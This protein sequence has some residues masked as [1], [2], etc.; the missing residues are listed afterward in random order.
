MRT[1]YISSQQKA[2]TFPA[3]FW[4]L[5]VIFLAS[6]SAILGALFALFAPIEPPIITKTLGKTGLNEVVVKPWKYTL[7]R[8]VNILVMGIDQVPDIP[9]DSPAIFT[10]RSDSLLLVRFHPENGDLNVLSIPRDTQVEIPEVGL[11]KINQANAIGGEELTQKV[12]SKT[13]NN[14]SIDRYVRVSTGAFRE[15]VDLLGGVDVFV[16]NSMSYIDKTQK[17]SIQLNPGWQTLNGEQ[18]EKFSRF[19][20]VYGD[21]GR[22]QRQQLLMQS[23]RTRLTH[24]TPLTKLPQMIRVMQKYVDTNLS[25]EEILAL[26]NFSLNLEPSQIKMLMLPGE[27]STSNEVEPTNYW[28]VDWQKSDRMLEEYFDQSSNYPSRKNSRLYP[29]DLKI[30]IQ[31]GS[32]NRQIAEKVFD[33]LTE[34][35]FKNVTIEPAFPLSQS[36]TTIIVQQGDLN[37]AKILQETLGLGNLEVSSTGIL[38]SDLTLRIGEDYLKK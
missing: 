38:G 32:K 19:R 14:I 31:N 22:I 6:T 4:L 16:P 11:S 20:D 25:F 7:T 29:Y 36:Q 10:G 8:P 17:L 23:I 34:K 24:S 1:P 18:A 2:K 27:S 15:L 9:W 26:A 35:G 3:L 5:V 30:A 21:V 33:D 37:A 12:V 13:F 28:L